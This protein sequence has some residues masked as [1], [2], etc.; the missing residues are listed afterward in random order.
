MNLFKFFKKSLKLLQAF[1]NKIFESFKKLFIE[2]FRS[3]NL[4]NCQK[5]LLKASLKLQHSQFLKAS[6]ESFFKT[7]KSFTMH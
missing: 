2:T 7:I 3:S 5:L 6:L 1:L 4:L